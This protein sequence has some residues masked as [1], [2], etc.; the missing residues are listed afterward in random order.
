VVYHEPCNLVRAARSSAPALELLRASGA[1][2]RLPDK[3]GVSTFCCGGGG[4]N[5][6][7]QVETEESRI[8]ALR[9]EQLLATGARS[10]A[11]SCPFCLTMLRD[12][13]AAR[14]DPGIEVY[15]PAESLA[16]AQ[17][18]FSAPPTEAPAAEPVSE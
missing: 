16:A 7:Y 6:F 3:N 14:G 17:P 15:D 11:V 1:V 8:S 10:V 12:A 2:V 4:G 5:S 18:P 13:V 9:L